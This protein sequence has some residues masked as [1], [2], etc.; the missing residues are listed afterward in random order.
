VRRHALAETAGAF[1]DGASM[2]ELE[3]ATSRYLIDE[4]V[5]PL[6][7]VA[8]EEPRYTTHELLASEREIIDGAQRRRTERTGVLPST[9]EPDRGAAASLLSAIRASTT[10]ASDASVWTDTGPERHRALRF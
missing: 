2:Q 7:V 8:G 3:V 9:L 10:I 1:P 4:T 5:A 6:T